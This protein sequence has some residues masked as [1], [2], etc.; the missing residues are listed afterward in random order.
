MMLGDAPAN[1]I[2]ALIAV[3]IA[4][5]VLSSVVPKIGLPLL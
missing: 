4:P 5:Q 2:T 1:V 3:A